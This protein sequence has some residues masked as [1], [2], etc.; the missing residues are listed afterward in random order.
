MLDVDAMAKALLDGVQTLMAKELGPIR[1]SLADLQM[2]VTAL[3]R[4]PSEFVDDVLA[5]LKAE[6]QSN[7]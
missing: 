2:R 4:G 5:Q 1:A 3:E 7:E 6:E